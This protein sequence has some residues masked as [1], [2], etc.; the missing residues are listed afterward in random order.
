MD[1]RLNRLAAVWLA[2]ASVAALPVA[3]QPQ[4][5][6]SP[7]Q[8]AASATALTYEAAL[9]LATTRNLGVEAA[10]RQRAIRDAQV[11]TARQW[12]NPEVGVDLTRDTPHEA[13]TVTLPVELGGKRGRRID[14]AKEEANQADI[15]L[16]T[17]MVTLRRNL[18]QAFAGLLAADERV[19]LASET[20]ALA[21][22]AQE[23][24]KARFDEGASPRLDVLEAALGT[25]R[26]RADLDLARSERAAAQADFNAVMDHSPAVRAD[27]VGDL[28]AARSPDL[29]AATTLALQSNPELLAAEHEVAV[30][31]RRTSFLKADRIPTP[32][33]SVG[34]VFNAPDEFRAGA[35]VGIGLAVPLFNRN[36]GE[37]AES[38]ASTSQLRAHRDATRRTVENA[39]FA[40]ISRID[41]QRQQV[42]TYKTSI[43]PAATE[44]ATLAEESYKAGRSP[45]LA[46]LDA[47]RSLRDVRREYLQVLLD[48]Q[49]AVADLEEVV[50]ASIY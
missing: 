49:S 2:A 19:R 25:A 23:V 43:L 36:Q 27:V 39:V 41:A 7:P 37:I 1:K 16:R 24:T 46:F 44:L 4:A 45:V 40:A 33:F 26:A 31:L 18:R 14:L 32:S 50:G 28:A 20:L 29:A 9:A 17:E 3:A 30:E 12:A 34:G 10:R 47:Q 8:A 22:R 6:S 15:D 38:V 48:F 5:A 42:D 13:V 21:E 11:R 35:S